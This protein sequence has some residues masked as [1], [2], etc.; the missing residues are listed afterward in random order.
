M[1]NMFFKDKLGKTDRVNIPDVEVEVDPNRNIKPKRARTPAYIP[2]FRRKA[3]DEEF[4]NMVSA[5][6]LEKVELSTPW[7]S[8]AFPV[9]KEGSDPLKVRWVSDFKEVN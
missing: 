5:G 4:S 9:Q 2:I 7:V 1:L 6:I 3:A 8:R